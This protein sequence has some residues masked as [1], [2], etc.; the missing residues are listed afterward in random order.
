MTRF[1]SRWAE[2]RGSQTNS[3][4]YC[5]FSRQN[6]ICSRTRSGAVPPLLLREATEAATERIAKTSLVI[7][8]S[9]FCISAS[10]ICSSGKFSSSARFTMAPAMRWA[11][12]NGLPATRTSQSAR[13]VAVG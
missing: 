8:G 9:I 3:A 11:V 1:G 12:R 5:S 13:S 7:S 2:T 4:A 6:P 10:G